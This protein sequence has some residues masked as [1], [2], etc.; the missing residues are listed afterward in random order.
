MRSGV[1][2]KRDTWWKL[3][4]VAELTVK[5][6]SFGGYEVLCRMRAGTVM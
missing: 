5:L 6:Y 2:L 1:Q 3:V 4:Y